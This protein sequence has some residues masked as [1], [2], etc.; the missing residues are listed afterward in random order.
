M[1]IK[2]LIEKREALQQELEGLLNAA[3]TENRALKEDEAA[4][5]DAVEKEIKEI[6][7]TIKREERARKMELKKNVVEPETEDRAALEERAFANFIRGVVEERS[8]V[9]FT[10][11][12]NGAVLPRSIANK[13]ISKVYDICPIF[14]L[15][16]QYRVKGT[17]TIPYYDETTQEITMAY[18]DEFVELESTAGKFSS[19][20][21]TGF[22]AGAL[23]KVSKKLLNNSDFDLVNF[24][25]LKVAEAAKKWIEK[26][27]LVGTNN[28]IE[29]LK[30]VTQTVTAAAVDKVTA[31][32]LID[33]QE[34]VPDQ[35]QAGAIWIMNR[36]TRKAIRKLKDGEGNYLL[37][38][39]FSARWG[40]TLLGKDVYT[41][42]NMPD[43][44]AGEIAIYYGD[45]S[46][47]ATKITEDVSIEVL[48]EK[49]A[50]QHAIGVVA[51]LEIDAKV[52]NA[53]KIAKLKM[54]TA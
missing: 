48:R 47:L 6:D 43:M 23:S 34:E 16:T 14:Q 9:N 30:G 44:K 15:S 5:F 46:G 13:I 33:L 49:F 11:G 53:Q 1:N 18:A 36:K 41:T 39:D 50:T 8:D 27:L 10:V 42:D 2:G 7:D 26:E 12:D 40:Y 32:E 31:D 3:E 54:K 22:L 29:G 45:M 52:E 17:L 25:V 51:W 19:I 20:S 24:V 21:L 35:Y 38:R 37:N 28:K 4:R